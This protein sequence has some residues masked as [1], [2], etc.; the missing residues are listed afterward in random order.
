MKVFFFCK[1][2]LNHQEDAE[3]VTSDVFVTLWEHKGSTT[4][5]TLEAFLM[6]TAKN[7]CLDHIKKI[8]RKQQRELNYIES[9]DPETLNNPI[10]DVLLY[11]QHAKNIL[12]PQQLTI[13]NLRFID[14]MSYHE[15]CTTLSLKQPTVANTLSSAL[16]RIK[17]S[18]PK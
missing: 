2:I 5:L 8:R 15:I 17:M 3:D 10:A 13:F 7:K 14:G 11:F 4:Q 9:N 18:F 6:I 16:K 1:K 12:T